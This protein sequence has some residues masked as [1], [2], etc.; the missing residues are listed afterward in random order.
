[1]AGY[2]PLGWLKDVK[3]PE[4]RKKRIKEGAIPCLMVD[5]A[6]DAIAFYEKAFGATRICWALNETEDKVHHSE[7]QFSNTL[8]FVYD[9]FPDYP[10]KI[11]SPKALGGP[12]SSIQLYADDVDAAFDRAVKAG[13]T[14]EKPLK[15][16]D[17]GYR[18]S[19]VVCPWGHH[20]GIWRELTSEELKTATSSAPPPQKTDGQKTESSGSSSNDQSD[21][22][23]QPKTKKQKTDG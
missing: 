21:T 10:N 23:D 7:L 5:G 2:D 12:T 17:Y 16:W 9:T 15:N 3:D 18:S 14:V 1:M 6:K 20:W 13:C 22:V 19:Q 8:V 11:K 4:G